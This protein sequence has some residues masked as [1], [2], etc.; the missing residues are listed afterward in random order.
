M[1]I[2]ID[3]RSIGVVSPYLHGQYF[4]MEVSELEEAG[5]DIWLMGHTHITWPEIPD[6]KDR[7]FNPGT[8]EPDRFDCRHGGRAF[9]HRMEADKSIR[10]EVLA[11]G[12]HRFVQLAQE[13]NSPGDGR[14][15]AEEFSGGEYQSSVVKLTVSGR[16]DPE[17][18]D[19][20]LEIRSRIRKNWLELKMEDAALRRKVTAEQ[21]RKEFAE[22]SFPELLLTS[23]PSDNEDE[24]QMAY[25]LLREVM[26]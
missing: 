16:L 18:Y 26:R 24:L 2:D 8:P 4:P 17:E 7:I 19:E 22:G 20:W 9:L 21:I 14:R 6:Q 25:E 13:L 10:T 15:L 23:I 12:H 5:V 3:H 11:T 1:L